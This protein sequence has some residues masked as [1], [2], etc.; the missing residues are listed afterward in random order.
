M[1][2]ELALRVAEVVVELHHLEVRGDLDSEVSARVRIRWAEFQVAVTRV[3]LGAQAV[4]A[5]EEL[6]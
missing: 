1:R 6:G 5:V 3:E 2:A 4:P